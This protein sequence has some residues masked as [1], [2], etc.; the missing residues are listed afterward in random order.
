[1]TPIH[2]KL[3]LAFSAA[4]L[5][6]SAHAQTTQ[7]TQAGSAATPAQSSQT[8]TAPGQSGAAATAAGQ[9]GATT[10]APA[11]PG[12]TTAAP[13]RAG[14]PVAPGTA[15]EPRDG[16]QQSMLADDDETFLENAIQ[17]SYAEIEGSQLALE[18]TES[19]EVRQFAEMMIK[20]HGEM[21]KE[22]TKLAT[23]KGMTPPEGPSLMQTTEITG[24]KALTGGAFD[25]M[26]VNRIGVAS[27]EAT[28]EMFEKASQEAQ[29]PDVKAMATKTL[30]KL[31]EHL[32]MA[33]ALDEK[34]D[35][36]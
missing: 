7:G 19:Q 1:M 18:K 15:A 30:P 16:D 14:E 24:L 9:P 13:T 4:L 32:Q 6:V 11:Q 10:T 33:Q 17:G 34:Q 22:A 20:D 36:Q 35:K 5:G 8:T 25:A 23:D 12:A 28:V 21:V 31:R 27:H 2:T 29:D 3:A 26:Y